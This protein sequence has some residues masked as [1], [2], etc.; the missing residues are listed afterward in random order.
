ML[1]TTTGGERPTLFW[2][3]FG[4]G[5]GR[6]TGWS[7]EREVGVAETGEVSKYRTEGEY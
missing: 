3:V 6:E 5:S 7:N 2:L 1:F 4:A